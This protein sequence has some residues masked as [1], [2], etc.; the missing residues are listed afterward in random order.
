MTGFRE[1]PPLRVKL[2]GDNTSYKK[3]ADESKAIAEDLAATINKTMKK[4]GGGVRGSSTRLDPQIRNMNYLDKLRETDHKRMMGAIKNFNYLD[5]LKQQEAQRVAQSNAQ[6]I[7]NLNYIDRLRQQEAKRQAAS[8]AQNLKNLDYLDRLKGQERARLEAVNTRNLRNMDYL[9]R[10]RQAERDRIAAS[11]AQA[12]RNMDYIDRLKQAEHDRIAASNAATLRNLDYIDRLKQAERDRIAASHAQTMRN[13]DYI[14]RLREQ[15]RNRLA[16]ANARA[17]ANMDYLER[18]RQTE[19]NRVAQSNTRTLRN[20]DYLDR[21]RQTERD[22]M[23]ASHARTLRNMDYL[24][25]LREQ[26]RQR[27]AAARQRLFGTGDRGTMAGLG[28]RADIYM[29]LN[30]IKGTLSAASSFVA[31]SANWQRMQVQMEGF[32]G[33]KQGA[34]TVM[35]Q[36][37]KSALE[38]PYDMQTIMGS[39]KTMMAYGAAVDQ[40]QEVTKMLGDVAGGSNEKLDRLS[41]GMAQIISLGKLQGN[42]LRQLTEHGFNPLRTIAERTLKPMQTLEDRMREL[43]KMKEDGLITSQAVITALR[44]ETSEGGRFAGT[45][46]RMSQDVW[47]LGQQI[48]ELLTFVQKRFTDT[49]LKEIEDSLRIVIRY[50][51]EMDQWMQ[52]N[53]EAVKSYAQWAKTI[54]TAVIAVNA[55]GMVMAMARWQGR[56]LWSALTLIPRAIGGILELAGAIRTVAGASSLAGSRFAML[57]GRAGAVGAVF[58]I[59][60]TITYGLHPH[61]RAFNREMERSAALFKELRESQ[62]GRFETLLG[63]IGSET[64]AVKRQTML[65]DAIAA[66]T[67]ELQGYNTQITNQKALV[68]K[69]SPSAWTLYQGGRKMWAAEVANLSQLESLRDDQKARLDRLNAMLAETPASFEFDSSLNN[70]LG[71]IKSAENKVRYMGPVQAVEAGSSQAAVRMHEYLFNRRAETARAPMNEMEVSKDMAKSLRKIE[72]N[73]RSKPETKY[74]NANLV[75]AN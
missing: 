38:S 49:L 52:A 23:A 61:I 17:L 71:G 69:L 39:V 51:K 42:E 58:A 18:L 53:P 8:L 5:R 6:A 72:A 40:A 41:L 63:D 27:I 36:M 9:D 50:L 33:S 4:A 55:L 14:E 2:V 10:L 74:D 59:F 32:T 25:R 7:K 16:A 21:L 60:S 43:N 19:R 34:A 48:K 1:L 31:A 44:I 68:D 65:N 70:M 26:E 35:E 75:G 22:R 3:M 62:N 15:E 11:N 47:G 12:L 29:H 73:T 67:R 28:D 57:A 37:R 30:A 66:G 64:D 54:L 24:D 45:A 56:L 20:M 13:M 46:K